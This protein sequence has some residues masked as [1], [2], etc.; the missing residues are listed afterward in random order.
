MPTD[1]N[2]QRAAA[3]VIEAETLLITAG[4]GMSVDSGLP[5]FRGDQGFWNIHPCYAADGL[6]FRDLADPLWF[7]T[8]PDRAWGFYGYR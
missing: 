7:E 2:I 4:A 1:N 5:D 8:H 6:T 3:A